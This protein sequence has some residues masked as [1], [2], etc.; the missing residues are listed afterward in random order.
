MDPD[1]RM[2]SDANRSSGV[3]RVGRS[4]RVA[5]AARLVSG[6]QGAPPAAGSG[7]IRRA[8]ASGIDLSYFWAFLGRDRRV[9]QAA[10][11]VPQAGRTAMVFLSADGPAAQC[12]G[13]ADQHAERV[14]LLREV[15]TEAPR[16]LGDRL[17]LL[18]ALPSP[19]ETRAQDAFAEAGLSRLADLVYLRRPLARPAE[20]LPFRDWPPGVEVRPMRGLDDHLDGPALRQALERSYVDTLDCPGLCDMRETA[21]VIESHRAAGRFDP[22]LWWLVWHEG[23]PEGCVLLSVSPDQ[24]SVELVYI[25]LGPSLRG[26]G[27]AAPLLS[28]ALSRAERS[29]MS[30]VNCAVDARNEP[31]RAVYA[32]LGFSPFAERVAFVRACPPS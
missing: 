17:R 21:D 12:G 7:F 22:A 14:M 24:D 15:V 18:Q 8:E 2:D 30:V 27:L 31:A 10:L 20:P 1:S 25:G 29:G 5:A 16:A 4:T 3:V 6:D 11:V 9:R 28:A 19:Q 26:R 13:L 23:R 32:R